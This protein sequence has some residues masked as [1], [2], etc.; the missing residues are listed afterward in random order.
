[1]YFRACEHQWDK[2]APSASSA[3]AQCRPLLKHCQIAIHIKRHS[4][5]LASLRPSA[6]LNCA[7]E[8]IATDSQTPLKASLHTANLPRCADPTCVS[9]LGRLQSPLSCPAW[10]SAPF[11]VAPPHLHQKLWS[12]C[13]WGG[14][15]GGSQQGAH[16]K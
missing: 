13:C 9:A 12:C 1:M 5:L 4:V 11:A 10:A 14:C 7:N 6:R 2:P 15:M 16:G 3:L 8:M